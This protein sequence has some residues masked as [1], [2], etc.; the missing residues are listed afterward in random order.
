MIA[1]AIGAIWTILVVFW[2]RQ[3]HPFKLRNKHKED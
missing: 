3:F 1:L 2:L